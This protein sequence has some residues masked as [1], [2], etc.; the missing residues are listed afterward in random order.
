MFMTL[1]GA[2][3]TLLYRYT[4]QTNIT[5][6]SPI[7]GRTHKD[8]E[9]LIGLFINTLPVRIDLSDNPTFAELI[10]RIRRAALEAYQHQEVPLQTI[11]E[12]A[13]TGRSSSDAP[14][15]DTL[16]NL[17]PAIEPVHAA[18]ITLTEATIKTD[19]AK[20]DLS[21]DLK[22]SSEAVYGD[23]EYRSELFEP[24]TVQDMVNHWFR[25]L[26]QV[27]EDPSV[28][29]DDLS[30]VESSDRD[31][32]LVEW[33]QNERDY[34]SDVALHEL[35]EE[36]AERSPDKIAVEMG[37]SQLT[38]AQLNQ[39][40]NQLANYL[41]RT[42]NQTSS[43]VVLLAERSIEM[44][45]GILG[46]LKSGACYI[47]VDASTPADRIRFI[48]NE[49]QST[50]VTTH[51]ELGRELSDFESQRICLERDGDSIA[52]A[53]IICPT[54]RAGAH[55]LAYIIYTSGSTGEPKG[56][57]VEHH[58]V[59]NYAR[60]VGDVLGVTKADRVLQFASIGFDA[61]IEEIF[62]ALVNGATL[63]LRDADAVSSIPKFLERVSHWQISFA[64]LPTAFWHEL[65]HQMQS[66]GLRLPSC[67]KTV[68]IGGQKASSSALEAWHKI[69][70]S[71]VDLFNTYGPTETTVVTTIAKWN[72]SVD[73][74]RREFPIGHPIPNSSAY[75][76]DSNQNPVPV[77]VAGELYI[78]GRGVARG[79]FD[80]QQLTID[81]FLPCPF[82][83]TDVATH[84]QRM[85]R[86]GDRVRWLH[87]GQLEFLDR[88]DSQI[89]VRG[90]RVEPLEIASNLES[91]SS[92]QQCTVVARE[93]ES[94]DT[95]LIAY[96][97]A[98]DTKTPTS[99][100][101]RTALSQ[102]LPDYMIPNAFV[103]LDSFPL[104]TNGKVD[105]NALPKVSELPDEPKELPK[106]QVQ[107]QLASIWQGILGVSSIGIHDQFFELG[108]HSL[109]AMQMVSR[110]TDKFGVEVPLRQIFQKPTL[111]ELAQEI[112]QRQQTASGKANSKKPP[113]IAA[114]SRERRRKTA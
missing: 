12:E 65:A 33:N 18:G 106:T 74:P 76:L 88:V 53:P 22:Y 98:A 10:T 17:Q 46:I 79:Y 36:Q 95:Q 67:L 13:V 62:G 75:V 91:L 28:Q 89:K 99:R 55:D 31:Q 82:V 52:Q 3:Q 97:V 50:L 32:L 110:L 57:M 45:V 41:T 54:G 8:M 59:V 23:L 9:G 72:G 83:A 56:V 58:S 14:L 19:T 5:T 11:V 105:E 61:S 94:D 100:E 96:V 71:H 111:A 25:I 87:D 66:D 113:S 107:R 64:S 81:S 84:H 90:F 37:D 30:L 86:T 38:Y 6:G 78:A 43:R 101:L 35:I 34:P 27:C 93:S 85:Y 108:G 60:T 44:I 29:L 20:A 7:A 104:T 39:R 68:I 42:T 26:E 92:V 16:F 77:G 70:T 40:A 69:G 1:F 47:P 4:G 2:F 63:V 112:E 49:T 21:M 102:R 109:K 80:R 114:I 15:F 24:A 51:Q 73:A 103:F 48:L